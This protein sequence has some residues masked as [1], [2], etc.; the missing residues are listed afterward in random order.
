[1]DS[2]LLTSISKPNEE[3]NCFQEALSGAENMKAMIAAIFEQLL[4]FSK[5]ACQPPPFGMLETKKQSGSAI[6]YDK[7]V[8]LQKRLSLMYDK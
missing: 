6:N 3:L 7:N 4:V 2:I 5:F 1:M 8:R